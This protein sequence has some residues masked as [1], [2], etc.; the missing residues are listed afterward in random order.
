[1]TPPPTAEPLTE[2][3][4]ASTSTKETEKTKIIQPK[5][6]K[7]LA[8]LPIG[9][10]TGGILSLKDKSAGYPHLVNTDPEPVKKPEKDEKKD[11]KSSQLSQNSQQNYKKQEQPSPNWG[12]VPMPQPNYGDNPRFSLHKN[13]YGIQNTGLNYNPN[14]QAPHVNNQGI[15]LPVVNP[16][17]IDVRSAALQK[18]NSRLEPYQETH[19]FGQSYQNLS[20]D[21]KNFLND[22][23]PRFANQYRHWQSSQEN[24]FGNQEDKFRD[25]NFQPNN[26]LFGNNQPP[27]PGNWM[28]NTP[29]P[30]NFHPSVPWWKPDNPP[31]TNFNNY[32]APSLTMPPNYFSPQNVPNPYQQNLPSYQPMNQQLGQH[33]QENVPNYSIAQPLQG[34]PNLQSFSSN[35]GTYTPSVGYDSNMYPQF[36]KMGFQ[37]SP[38]SDKMGQ[39]TPGKDLVDLSNLNFGGN[40]RRNVP[41]V[42]FNEPMHS[43]MGNAKN[44]EHVGVCCFLKLCF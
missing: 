44:M 36:N 25:Q 27:R 20:G 4:D 11:V 1:M 22:L 24:Q 43:D 34:L 31:P 21:K 2:N 9:R 30:E 39:Y 23:P 5:A 16:K 8:N 13:A 17:E 14:Y 41:P 12:N 38:M 33:K 37:Q 15:R 3:A 18:Q 10:K 26:T 35:F 40:V 42:N 29:L 6:I 19:K 32:P 7:S 28:M